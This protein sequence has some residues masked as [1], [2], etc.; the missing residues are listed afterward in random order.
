M[1][2]YFA[3][4]VQRSQGDP[5][6]QFDMHGSTYPNLLKTILCL[7]D[8]SAFVPSWNGTN[9][10]ST[11]TILPHCTFYAF[12]AHAAGGSWSDTSGA[13]AIDASMSA[14]PATGLL[15]RRAI[16]RNRKFLLVNAQNETSAGNTRCYAQWNHQ[17]EI[18]N[19]MFGV[20]GP[21]KYRSQQWSCSTC[22]QRIFNSA[23]ETHNFESLISRESN[24]S[25]RKAISQCDSFDEMYIDAYPIRT[26]KL[27]FPRNAP[28]Q[29]KSKSIRVDR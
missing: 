14:S 3:E 1:T 13:D 29:R 23:E 26:S 12:C 11:F 5:L 7:L 6:F 22:R 21:L 17:P 28:D 18:R 15:T 9:K 25:F 2:Y 27:I 8:R 4:N 10:S 16:R 20:I 19:N 24:T